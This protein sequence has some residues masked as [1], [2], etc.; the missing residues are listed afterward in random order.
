MLSPTTHPRLP[1]VLFVSKYLKPEVR[2]RILNF[3]KR[4]GKVPHLRT[5]LLNRDA[6]HMRVIEPFM[7]QHCITCTCVVRFAGIAT[8]TNGE[9]LVTCGAV[10]HKA[11][12]MQAS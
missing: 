9:Y 1:N 4:Q 10:V 11:W 3:N 7:H 2:E 12:P 6:C 8:P 5:T